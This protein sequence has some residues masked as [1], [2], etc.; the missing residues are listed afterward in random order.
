M[1]D[2]ELKDMAAQSKAAMQAA[3]QQAEL[4]AGIEYDP[5]TGKIT[6]KQTYKN[7]DDSL[8]ISAEESNNRIAGNV[9]VKF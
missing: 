3:N 9:K 8:E 5:T 2:Q 4:N 7:K 1:T 6:A